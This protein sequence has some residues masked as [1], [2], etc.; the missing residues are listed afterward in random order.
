[1]RPPIV[2]ITYRDSKGLTDV[3][4]DCAEAVAISPYVL[5]PTEAIFGRASKRNSHRLYQTALAAT[6]DQATCDP[7]AR[8]ML[9]ELRIGGGDKGAQTV[10]PGSTHESGELIAWEVN[11]EPAPCDP[12]E[13]E[14][15]VRLVAA[16][17]LLARYWPA[18]GSRHQAALIIGGFLSRANSITNG[19]IVPRRPKMPSSPTVPASIPTEVFGKNVAEKVAE[20]IGYQ[21]DDGIA[22]G[23]D[24]LRETPA[25]PVIFDPKPYEFPDPAKIPPRQWL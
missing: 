1:V 6:C 2:S 16:F 22:Q 13:L 17:S 24:G 14:A 19:A 7:R 9:L 5:P 15:K 3:D 23:P 4:L 21:G 18:E 20:W 8:N 25:E 11:G 12:A 10:F